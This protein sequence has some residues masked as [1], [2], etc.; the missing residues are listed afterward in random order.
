MKDKIPNL[1]MMEERKNRVK[2]KRQFEEW[3]EMENEIEKKVYLNDNYI[4]P[5]ISYDIKNFEEFYKQRKEILKVAL[6]KILLGVSNDYI[7]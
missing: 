6:N 2:N 1:Q 5:D 3:L 4:P 7:K